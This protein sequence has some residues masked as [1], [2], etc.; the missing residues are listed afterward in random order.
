MQNSSLFYRTV[1]S[2]FIFIRDAFLFVL[3][4]SWNVDGN[5]GKLAGTLATGILADWV[6]PFVNYIGLAGFRVSVLRTY[7]H[8]NHK[9]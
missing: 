6:L 8:C 9:E 7:R 2:T 5:I 1:L 4:I 3:V